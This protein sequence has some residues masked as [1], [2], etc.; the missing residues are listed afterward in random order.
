MLIIPG[1]AVPAGYNLL[2]F[3]YQK[4]NTI[5]FL[6]QNFYTL[7]SAD[8]FLTLIIQQTGMTILINLVQLSVLFF[9]AFSPSYF[10]LYRLN[11]DKGCKGFFEIGDTFD[12]GYHTAFILVITT[13]IFVY[14]LN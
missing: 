12:Y 11:L 1:L 5:E 8:F 10:L 13:I 6:F 14:A 4:M 3:L 7:Q 2:N 9:W